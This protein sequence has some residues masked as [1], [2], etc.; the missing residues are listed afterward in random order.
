MKLI[1]SDHFT[2]YTYLKSCRTPEAN[3][4]RELY[5]KKKKKIIAVL[6]AYW[7]NILYFN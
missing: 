2:I 7:V 3:A 5:L 1:S 6:L 4:P